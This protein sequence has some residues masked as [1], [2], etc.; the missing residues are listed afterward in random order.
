M[1]GDGEG[2]KK[3]GLKSGSLLTDATPN[4]YACYHASKQCSVGFT[5]EQ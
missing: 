4:A 2:G 5:F 3:G 1:D